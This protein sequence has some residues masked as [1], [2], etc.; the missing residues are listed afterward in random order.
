MLSKHY[1]ICRRS[2]EKED[3]YINHLPLLYNFSILYMN[4]IIGKEIVNMQ[5]KRRTDK[6]EEN[7]IKREIIYM[8][9]KPTDI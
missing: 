5:I 1:Q 6:D 8:K 3:Y 2:R 7:V 9:R 4:T